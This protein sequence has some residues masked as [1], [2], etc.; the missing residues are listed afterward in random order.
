MPKVVRVSKH[1]IRLNREWWAFARN[2]YG[3]IW[4]AKAPIKYPRPENIPE[5]CISAVFEDGWRTFAFQSEAARDLFVSRFSNAKP[6]ED[7]V[8]V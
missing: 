7:P 4:C 5:H 2:R 3:P 8:D 6:C 1:R